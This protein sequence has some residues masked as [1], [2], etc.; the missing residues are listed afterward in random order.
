MISEPSLMNWGNLII[1][2]GYNDRWRKSRRMIHPLL[3]KKAVEEFYPAQQLQARLLLQRLLST[4]DTLTESDEVD[5]EL[6]RTFAAILT[7]SIYGYK[8]NSTDD[9]FLRDFR[10]AANNLA[11]A[12]SP[13]NFLVNLFPA[14][15]KI[16]EWAPWTGWKRIAREWREQQQYTVDYC[17]YQA[18]NKIENGEGEGSMIRSLLASAE[19]LGLNADEASC[20]HNSLLSWLILSPAPAGT[21]TSASTVLVFFLAMIQFPE[22]QK[23]AQ[24]EI[25]S[26]VGMNRLPNMDDRSRLSYVNRLVDEV[27]RWRPVIPTGVP[28]SSYEDDVYK[29]YKIPKGAIIFGNVWAMSHDPDVYKDPETFDPD[30]YLGSNIPAPPAFG[31]GRRLCLGIHYAEAALFIAVAS[32]L[33]TFNISPFEDSDQEGETVKQDANKAVYRPKPF[34]LKLTARSAEHAKL[35]QTGA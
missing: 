30:R 35:I 14:L 3:N 28:H 31:F 10:T 8:I 34:R 29:G 27:M 19:G 25:D 1:S 4:S 26:V 13:A 15:V 16:P 2:L 32:I 21:D 17:Y 7:D 9:Q 20:F 23:K 18:K 12:A 22:I 5:A 24:A 11:E 33:S 6:Y